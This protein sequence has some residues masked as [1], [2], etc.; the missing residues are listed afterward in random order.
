MKWNNRRFVKGFF[1]YEK[2]II[3]K[4]IIS[5]LIPLLVVLVI[6]II[7]IYFAG[8]VL[9]KFIFNEK[10]SKYSTLLILMVFYKNLSIISSIPKISF[11]IYNK[12]QITLGFLISHALI[13][14]GFLFLSNSLLQLIIVLLFFELLL[15]LG[16]SIFSYKIF[17]IGLKKFEVDSDKHYLTRN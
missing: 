9:L 16:L 6:S 4:T 1:N 5:Y 11:I 2:R 3:K 13:I 15:L 17:K 12:V 14:S 7:V 10:M 8:D